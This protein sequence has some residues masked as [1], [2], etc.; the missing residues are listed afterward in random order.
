MRY[1]YST[2][3]IVLAITCLFISHIDA[4]ITLDTTQF[5]KIEDQESHLKAFGLFIPQ[6]NNQSAWDYFHTCVFK[7][8]QFLNSCKE[9]HVPFIIILPEECSNIKTFSNNDPFLEAGRVALTWASIHFRFKELGDFDV[10]VILV[11]H[12]P[13]LSEAAIN[14]AISKMLC[15]KTVDDPHQTPEQQMRSRTI[16]YEN[17][18]KLCNNFV[19]YNLS[20]AGINQQLVCTPITITEQPQPPVL[21]S[22]NLERNAY[23]RIVV[24]GGA[25]FL[26]SHLVKA[27]LDQGHQ[28]IVLDNLFCCTLRNIEDIQNHP[29]FVFFN[30]DVTQPFDIEGPVDKVIH[31][32]SVPSPEFY[33]RSPIETIESGL[34]GTKNCLDLA[35]RKYARFMFSSTSEVY[36]DPEVSPQPETYTGCV[37]P[38]GKRSQ[39]DESKRGAEALIRL[40]YDRYN[41]DVRIPR[42]FNTYGP[43][44][45]LND[46]RVVTNFIDAILKD[47]SLIINGD[48]YQTRS[49]AYVS[50]TVNGLLAVLRSDSIRDIIAFD[51]RIFNVGSPFE[52]TIK[53]LAEKMNSISLKYLNRPAKIVTR[54]NPDADDPKLRKPDI[55]RLQTI[56]HFSPTVGLDEGLE[57][58][59]EY[60]YNEQQKA[61]LPV[62]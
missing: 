14:Q 32:A 17:L 30:F 11:P 25:G 37:N 53:E 43:G 47:S 2:R 40:Y 48:G 10:R 24:T 54:P 6:R 19:K 20:A 56:T 50:D 33:Y 22:P 3:F 51:N 55:Q 9:Q 31:L 59:F 4:G 7:F 1:Y 13:K 28:V 23:D 52:F 21:L 16:K 44:M 60:F 38:I 18:I 58:T 41:L 39:Y 35:V 42:I 27:L 57:K 8:P 62:Q 46:G 29:N 12:N 49:F 36:G 5:L 61:A 26:G 34:K 15:L 45:I